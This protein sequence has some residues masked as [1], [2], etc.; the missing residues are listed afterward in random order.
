MVQAAA[1]AHIVHEQVGE[2]VVVVVDPG[3]PLQIDEDRRSTPGLGG[4][5]F[6]RPIALV[7]VQPVVLR[8]QATNRSIQPSLS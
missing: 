4:K 2:I 7:V 3:Q 1:F 5:L 6:E 8:S